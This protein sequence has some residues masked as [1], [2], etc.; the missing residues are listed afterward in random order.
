LFLI[1]KAVKSWVATDFAR[2]SQATDDLKRFI[3]SHCHEDLS[4]EDAS[5][6]Y[7]LLYNSV[8][9][10]LNL[11][12][13]NRVSLIRYEDLVQKPDETI[14]RV[15]GTLGLTWRPFM[16]DEVS[17]AFVGKNPKPEIS[18]EIERACLDQWKRLT[19]ERLSSSI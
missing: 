11:D 13:N 1:S 19:G 6:L 9:H 3:R 17:S 16:T 15:C 12:A 8:F 10:F 18:P 14:K 7:W 2:H 5:A 4:L